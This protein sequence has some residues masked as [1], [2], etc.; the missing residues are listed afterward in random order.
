MKIYC[1]VTMIDGVIN[2]METF[3]TI[4]LARAFFYKFIEKH[5]SVEDCDLTFYAEGSEDYFYW[6]DGFDMC[7]AE[8]HIWPTELNMTV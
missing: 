1:A 2:R 6:D 8:I 4:E 5:G 3:A 7:G